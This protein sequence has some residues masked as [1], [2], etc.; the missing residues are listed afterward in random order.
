MASSHSRTSSGSHFD[1]VKTC[2]NKLYLRFL[3]NLPWAGLFLILLSSR[4]MFNSSF[5][6]TMRVASSMAAATIASLSLFSLS[7]TSLIASI[8][9]SATCRWMRAARRDA[10]VSGGTYEKINNK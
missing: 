3:L 4:D 9:I 5:L 6:L 7:M 1:A 2:P 10:F 8:L